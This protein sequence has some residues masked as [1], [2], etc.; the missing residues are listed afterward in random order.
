MK[1]HY[2]FLLFLVVGCKEIE[3]QKVYSDEISQKEL[4]QINW[5][6]VE[7]Y[8]EFQNCSH[9]VEKAEKKKCFEQKVTEYFYRKLATQQYVVTDSLDETFHLYIK[10][11][12]AG[13]P[14]LDSLHASE[15]LYI[16]LPQLDSLMTTSVENLPVLEPAYKRGIPVST[17]FTLPLE[18][19]TK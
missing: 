15:D 12:A 8:P 19:K 2:L 3:T 1:Y 13:K 16:K 7:T 11:T 6:E 10:I 4:Q 18:I 5:S 14:V 9:C 17:S